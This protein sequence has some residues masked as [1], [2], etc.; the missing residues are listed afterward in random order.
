MKI[1]W[2]LLCLSSRCYT[3]STRVSFLLC[4]LCR[5]VKAVGGDT[6]RAH[7]VALGGAREAVRANHG[8]H[9]GRGRD[10][11][12]GDDARV[13]AL[14]DAS[15]A[16]RDR[17]LGDRRGLEGQRGRGGHGAGAAEVDVLEHSG[18]G[19]RQGALVGHGLAGGT[20]EGDRG[21][22]AQGG[23][24]AD[25]HGAGAAEGQESAD[26]GALR[27]GQ[28]AVEVEAGRAEVQLVGR[29]GGGADHV[30]GEEVQLLG[31]DGVVEDKVAAGDGQDA[32]AGAGT[33]EGDVSADDVQGARPCTLR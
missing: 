21:K 26:G 22:G 25:G 33:N 9:G 10:L 14:E 19:D 5:E 18:G 16:Q 29:Q 11:A 17:R 2:P 1:V 15:A 8:A 28:R 31:N 6:A 30:A 20:G 24:G 13:G 23:S 27:H 4:N 12:D 32:N 3:Q 7:I